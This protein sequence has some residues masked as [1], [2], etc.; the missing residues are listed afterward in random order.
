MEI[1]DVEALA[2][3]ARIDLT[4]VEKQDLLKDFDSILA[5]VRAIEQVQ[6]EDTE[7]DIILHNIWRDDVSNQREYSKELITKQFPDSQDGFLKV[8]KIL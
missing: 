7:S 4:E 1:K 3:L 6:I 8:K 5:Y 2:E